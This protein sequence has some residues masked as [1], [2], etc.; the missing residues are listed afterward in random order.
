MNFYASGTN[1]AGQEDQESLKLALAKLAVHFATR[2]RIIASV[3]LIILLRLLLLPV[4]RLSL[5]GPQHHWQQKNQQQVH[6][7]CILC[8]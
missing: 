4:H 8:K 2:L 6:L 1:Y 5:L 3:I 7:N